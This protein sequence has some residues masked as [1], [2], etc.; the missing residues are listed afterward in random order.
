MRSYPKIAL[1]TDADMPIGRALALGLARAGWQVAVHYGRDVGAAQITADAISYLGP[2]NCIVRCDLSDDAATRT[3][4]VEVE[5]KLGRVNCVVN[6]GGLADFDNAATFSTERLNAH[7]SAHLTGPVVLTRALHAATPANQ[8]SVAINLVDQKLQQLQPDFLSYT[9]AH[10]ALQTATPLLAQALAPKT[11]V[12][13]IAC[14][15]LPRATSTH[16]GRHA[17]R[18]K[19]SFDRTAL[20]DMIAAVRFAAESPAVTGSL[21]LVNGGQHL[22]PAQSQAAHRVS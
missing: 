12:V 17:A 18:S 10:A 4:L 19:Q 8:R 11:R 13:G 6:Y 5:E 9:L 14:D 16:G 21:L 7:I 22:F 15:M 1:V 20:S 3:M 2:K